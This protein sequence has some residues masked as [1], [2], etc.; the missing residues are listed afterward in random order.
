M[1]NVS[2]FGRSAS[3][4]SFVQQLLTS[5]H[6]GCLWL[7]TRILIDEMLIKRITGLPHQGKDPTEAFVGKN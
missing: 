7:G 6:D 1:I 3:I 5:I 4:T 2:Q